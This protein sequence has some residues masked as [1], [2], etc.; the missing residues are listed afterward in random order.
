MMQT[1]SIQKLKSRT[2]SLLGIKRWMKVKEKLTGFQIYNSGFDLTQSIFVHIPKTAG[3]S[4]GIALYNNGSTGHYR[5][6]EYKQCDPEKFE[7]YFKF[8]FVRNPVDRFI[9]SFYYLKEGG[10]TSSDRYW[11]MTHLSKFETHS[12]LLEEMAVNAKTKSK[13]LSWGHFEPQSSFICNQNGE[14]MVDYVGKFESVAADFQSICAR[15]NKQVKLKHHNPTKTRPNAPSPS[16]EE[17]QAIENIY[18][19]DMEAFY[20]K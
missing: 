5:W 2:K 14:V 15:L 10:K 12:Q 11:A 20:R 1:N 13:I 8:A 6:W 18:Q 4:I 3:T 9:S 16:A 17:I 19:I 7:N